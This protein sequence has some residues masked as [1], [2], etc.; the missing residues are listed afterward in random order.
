MN[1]EV[2]F[3]SGFLSSGSRP[4]SRPVP[5]RGE[6][7]WSRQSARGRGARLEAALAVGP[8]ELEGHRSPASG[9]AP[10][11][12]ALSKAPRRRRPRRRS[13]RVSSVPSVPSSQSSI[14]WVSET[15]LENSAPTDSPRWI[16]LIASPMSGATDS[17]VILRDAL[18]LGQRDR[19]GQDDL[20]QRSMPRSGRPPGR[21]GRRGWRRRRS[22]SRPRARARG[23][24]RPACRPCRSRRRR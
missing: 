7:S 5:Q 17:V 6:R 21:S 23:R 2:G 10:G 20:A 9:T 16:R 14:S 24:S 8:V 3:I 1:R 18:A 15:S 11:E 12:V 19:V 13:S 22:R 4:P